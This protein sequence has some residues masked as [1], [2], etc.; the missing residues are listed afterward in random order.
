[1][2]ISLVV[3][4]AIY[5]TF[6]SQQD[7]FVIQTQVSATQQNLRAALYMITR[8]IQ[9]AGYYT[10]FDTAIYNVDW[11]GDPL[12][13]TESSLPI[14]FG[15]D[16]DTSSDEVKDNTDLIVIVKAGSED[17][18]VIDS[19]SGDSVGA[20]TITLSSNP[21]G[22]ND[23]SRKYG[24]LVQSDLR[25]S[26]FFEVNNISGNT[27]TL[28][29]N[30]QD[31][32]GDGD[33]VFR[34]DVIIYKVDETDENLERRNLGNENGWQVVAEN[35][36]SFHVQYL[37]ST[38]ATAVNISA[39]AANNVTAVQIGILSRTEN[40]IRGYTDPHTYNMPGE[41]TP[42]TPN[43]AFQRRL[44]CSTIQTRNI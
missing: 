10:S 38:G 36:D 21:L 29:N 43:D 11:D 37:L 33:M 18:I 44:M 41:T 28:T 19:G 42:Y 24:V 7:S 6:R 8:D 9:M 39:G 27:L 15:R 13:G 3:M 17:P 14:L 40:T 34:A 1:M 22:L 30:L 26:E 25:R 20:N 35:I 12:T 2:A 23:G 32:Y 4:A 16:N 31:N 5:S